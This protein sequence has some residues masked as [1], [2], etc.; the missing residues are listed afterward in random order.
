VANTRFLDLNGD[1][2]SDIAYTS[3]ANWYYRFSTGLGFSPPILGPAVGS[4]TVAQAIVLDYDGDGF[5]DLLVPNGA[6][7]Y[8]MRSTGEVLSNP[9]N[10]TQATT[11][12]VAYAG[13]VN[14]DGL[15][16]VLYVKTTN[17]LAY[18]PHAGVRPDLLNVATDSYGNTVDFDYIPITQGS[19]TKNTTAVFPNQDYQGPIDVVSQY[20]ASTLMDANKYTMTYLY[21]WGAS[22]TAAPTTWCSTTTTSISRSSGSMR[23]TMSCSPAARCV[24]VSGLQRGAP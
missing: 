2:Y 12:S 21:W 1:G 8:Y 5:D 4:Q 16:D 20:Q 7:W 6:N 13:D 24:R 3:G 9:V 17:V 19:Y 15:D 18:R 22:R 14:G 10:T 11:A 23:S